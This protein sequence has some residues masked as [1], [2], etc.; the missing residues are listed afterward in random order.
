M[1]IDT[2]LSTMENRMDGFRRLDEA[3]ERKKNYTW[4]YDQEYRAKKEKEAKEFEIRMEEMINKV[5]NFFS[6]GRNIQKSR[7]LLE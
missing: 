2:T 4:P 7:E 1:I 3:V 5:V 6:V